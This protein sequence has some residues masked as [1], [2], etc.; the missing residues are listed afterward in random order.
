M[1]QNVLKVSPVVRVSSRG[2][3]TLHLRIIDESHMPGDLFQT[4]H[5]QVL[6]PLNGSYLVSRFQKTLGSPGV[7]PRHSPAKHPNIQHSVVQVVHVQIGNFEL[8]PL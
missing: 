6:L 5:F 3:Q 8:S 4:R 1:L 7:E 2:D